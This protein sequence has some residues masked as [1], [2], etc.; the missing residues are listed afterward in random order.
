[1]KNTQKSG[2][3]RFDFL[4]DLVWVQVC[5]RTFCIF[6]ESLVESSLCGTLPNSFQPGS[7]CSSS[8]PESFILLA[9]RLLKNIEKKYKVWVN[10]LL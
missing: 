6:L 2:P 10:Y 9:K 5:E 1:M 7:L 4:T 3:L 8:A